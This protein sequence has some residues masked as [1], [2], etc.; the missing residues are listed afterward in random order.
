MEEDYGCRILAGGMITAPANAAYAFGTSDFSVTALFETTQPGALAGCKADYGETGGAGW[1]L[2]LQPNGQIKFATDSG[3]GFYQVVSGPTGALNGT[4]HSV[5]AVRSNGQLQIYYDGQLIPT[6]A[7]S[8]TP[9]PVNV[10]N[11]ERLTIG[12]CDPKTEPY[13]QFV[14]I[15]EDVTLWNRGLNA[16]DVW[17]TMFNKVTPQEPGLVGLWEMN[18]NLADSSLT[19]NTASATGSTAFTPVMHC[20]WAEAPNAY[21][22]LSRLAEDSQRKGRVIRWTDLIRGCG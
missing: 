21:S 20:L 17:R 13:R 6:Q 18:R 1:L 12:A 14:G 7:T 5:A 9:T 8:T 2:V 10:S 19:A 22:Y 3:Y 15:I 4:W 11:T 16:D